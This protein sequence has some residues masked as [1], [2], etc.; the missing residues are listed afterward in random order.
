MDSEFPEGFM[1]FVG[2]QR[3]SPGLIFNSSQVGPL[4]PDGM[5]LY[6]RLQLGQLAFGVYFIGH[7]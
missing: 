4:R 3:I 6:G 7:V 5:V 2:N 1:Y